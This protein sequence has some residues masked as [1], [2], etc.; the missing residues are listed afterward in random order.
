MVQGFSTRID[1]EEVLAAVNQRA[2]LQ[3][4]LLEQT[5]L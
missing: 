2:R 4:R 3:G 1:A 5:A